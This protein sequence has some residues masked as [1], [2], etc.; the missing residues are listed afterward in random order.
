[1]YNVYMCIYI[2]N[3]KQ[4]LKYH[5]YTFLHSKFYNISV[6]IKFK[7]VKNTNEILL[8]YQKLINTNIILVYRK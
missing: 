6:K 7:L 8:Q 5:I 2:N 1:M 4:M 3:V